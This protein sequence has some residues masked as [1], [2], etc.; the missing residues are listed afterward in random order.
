[1][2]LRNAGVL[3]LALGIGLFC[4]TPASIAGHCPGKTMHC[5]T[6]HQHCKH[7]KKDCHRKDVVS[8]ACCSGEHKILTSALHKTGLAQRLHA[9]GPFTLFAPNDAAFWRMSKDNFAALTGDDKQLSKVLKYHVLPRK[10][11]MTDFQARG[12]MQTLEGEDVMTNVKDG[13]VWIDGARIVGEGIPCRNGI[14]YV[15]DQVL[16]PER[17]K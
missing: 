9:P 8:A 5:P 10:V 7:G 17:G 13:V 11:A 12:S 14:V 3:G 1:M 6:S 15:I 16:I 4:L 2:K